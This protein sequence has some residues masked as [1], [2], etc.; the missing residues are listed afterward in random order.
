MKETLKSH[1]TVTLKPEVS[2]VTYRLRKKDDSFVKLT[3]YSKNILDE[4]GTQFIVVLST[5]AE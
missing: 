4:F 1:A 5:I 3:S 2:I